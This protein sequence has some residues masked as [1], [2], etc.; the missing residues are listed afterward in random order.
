MTFTSFSSA[1]TY[2]L[3]NVMLASRVGGLTIGNTNNT[4]DITIGNATSI[5][6]PITV[7]GGNISVNAGLTSTATV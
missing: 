2:P 6:G 4:A 7:Y 5:A 1:L 3:T